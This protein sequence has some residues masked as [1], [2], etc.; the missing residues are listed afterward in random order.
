MSQFNT[1]IHKDIIELSKRG[2][3]KAQLKLYELYSK[4][5]YSIALRLLNN[6]EDAND[7][8]QDAFTEAFRKIETFRFDSTFGA[9][10]KKIIINRCINELNRRNT[11]VNYLEDLP[12]EINIPDESWKYDY[13]TKSEETVKLIRKAMEILPDGSKT[14]FSLYLLEGYDHTE[15]AQILNISESTSKSQF[16]RAKNKIKDFLIHNAYETR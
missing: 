13:E 8:L 12:N 6:R 3:R 11:L 1:D 7:V 10:L 2:S 4:A 9:W 14:I 5:M 15:I 16:M